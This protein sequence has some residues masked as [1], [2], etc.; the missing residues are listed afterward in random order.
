MY[1]CT[2]NVAAPYWSHIYLQKL[3]N[4]LKPTDEEKTSIQEA[5]QEARKENPDTVL[6]PAEEFLH[7]LSTIP[8]LEA[9]LSLWRF[10][11]VFQSVESVR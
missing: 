5:L 8:E 10:N 3:I 1:I 11:Y 7:T 4:S 6:G 2:V 9:R